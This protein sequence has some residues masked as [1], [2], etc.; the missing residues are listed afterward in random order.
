MEQEEPSKK[1]VR[2]KDEEGLQKSES[3]QKQT[4]SESIGPKDTFDLK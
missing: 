2:F 4:P 3:P 1:V